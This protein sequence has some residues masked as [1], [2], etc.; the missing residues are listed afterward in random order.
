MEVYSLL[1]NC[2]TS[3]GFKFYSMNSFSYLKIVLWDNLFHSATGKE[4]Y[5]SVCPLI[6]PEN[7]DVEIRLTE[8]CEEVKVQ[9]FF[10]C[11]K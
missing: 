9:G 7:I 3:Y 1:N 11:I 5:S 2:G 10:S 4:H 6:F 8:L